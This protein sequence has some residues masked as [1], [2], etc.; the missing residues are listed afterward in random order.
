MELKEALQ[1][2]R[3][4]AVDAKKGKRFVVNDFPNLSGA[5]LSGADLSRAD[6]PYPILQ[7]GPL[8]SRRDY[9]VYKSGIDQVSA[10]CWTGTLDAFELQVAET[11]GAS[12]YGR[13]YQAAI[14]FLRAL[15]VN[16]VEVGFRRQPP[17]QPQAPAASGD[18][19]EQ[20]A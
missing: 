8:G 20:D 14:Q 16:E 9:L 10:G 1:S 11:H 18:S 12:R 6:L 2:H 19:S 3:E 4:W 7:L 5:D 13:D 17:S 15:V